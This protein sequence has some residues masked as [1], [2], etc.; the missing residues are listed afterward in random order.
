MPA[1]NSRFALSSSICQILSPFKY[2]ALTAVAIGMLVGI[3]V[4]CAGPWLGILASAVGGFV[5]TLSVQTGLWV[6]KLFAHDQE[7]ADRD[8]AL[9]T[10]RRGVRAGPQRKGGRPSLA[11]AGAELSDQIAEGAVSE[12]EALATACK[13][14]SSLITARIA[15]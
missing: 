14:C 12:A 6:R 1:V 3:G 7:R 2:H 11:D 4:W 10:C 9:L 8:E 15:S 13:G 5:M